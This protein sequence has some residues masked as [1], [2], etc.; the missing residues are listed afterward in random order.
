M[1]FNSAFKGLT[2]HQIMKTFGG[3]EVEIIAFLTSELDNDEWTVTPANAL[4]SRKF[5][6]W[7]LTRGLVEL[8]SRSRSIS[9]EKCP[10]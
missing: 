2:V 10:L 8:Q 3:V 7:R 4:V 5:T 6:R 1:G 9:E